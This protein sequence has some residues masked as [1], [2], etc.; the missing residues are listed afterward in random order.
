MELSYYTYWLSYFQ[1]YSSLTKLS[2]HVMKD[3]LKWEPI[4]Y[5]N[6]N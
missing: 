3:M 5:L 2:M 6:Q 4:L 1:N